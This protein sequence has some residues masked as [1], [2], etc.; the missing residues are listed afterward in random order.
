MFAIFSSVKNQ[1]ACVNFCFQQHVS[2]DIIC[3]TNWSEHFLLPLASTRYPNVRQSAHKHPTVQVLTR[4]YHVGR[5][6][7]DQLQTCNIWGFKAWHADQREFP[8]KPYQWYIWNL[9]I[10]KDQ[11][12]CRKQSRV[13]VVVTLGFNVCVDVLMVQNEL[14]LELVANQSEGTYRNDQ[15]FTPTSSLKWCPHTSQAS[16]PLH[17]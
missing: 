12:L 16:L 9:N 10:Q 7:E 15:P 13:E 6:V 2:N 4:V 11:M 14:H 1:K 3:S 5:G 8:E 17:H